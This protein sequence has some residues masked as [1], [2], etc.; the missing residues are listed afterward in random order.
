MHYSLVMAA[1]VATM[2]AA[3]G[4]AQDEPNLPFRQDDFT[5]LTAN[6]QRP[7]GVGW[8]DGQIYT[9]CTGDGTVYEIDDTTGQTQTYIFGVRNAHTMVVERTTADGVVLWVPDYADNVLLRVTRAG[10]RRVESGLS[11]PW[12]IAYLDEEHFL[13]SNLLDNRIDRIS[14]D[15]QREA[16][17]DGL[18]APAGLL[19][20]EERLYVANTGS[21]RR[22]IEW[23]PR[24]SVAAG[25]FERGE[26]SEQVLV[27]GIQNATG[28]QLAV[29]G[30][31]YF[32]YAQGTRG[33]VGRVDPVECEQNGGCTA[34]DVEVVIYSDLEAPLAGL[35]ITPD[36]RLF[37]HEMFSPDLYWLALP[38]EDVN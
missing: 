16:V 38:S 3:P 21:T 7:N 2:A 25:L 11:G 6:V 31:L 22:A 27:S 10:A 19:L 35:T 12:G 13:V 34:D 32:A 5:L 18:A 9:A 14:R 8:L 26:I 15:G 24:D 33:L 36:M 28:L 4:R 23:Y 20:T 30:Y 17:L 29:D 37:V 1:L